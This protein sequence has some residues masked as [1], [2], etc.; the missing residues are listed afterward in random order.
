MPCLTRTTPHLLHLQS[1]PA[2]SF[3]PSSIPINS[4][5]HHNYTPFPISSIAACPTPPSLHP[6]ILAYRPPSI[7]S[8]P[9]PY[10]P[11]VQKFLWGG[12]GRR[13]VL[14]LP[15]IPPLI[16]ELESGMCSEDERQRSMGVRAVGPPKP[17]R[18]PTQHEPN[19]DSDEIQIFAKYLNFV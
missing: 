4:S 6:T 15:H 5:R 11:F 16:L 9:I 18:P 13:P 17:G 14:K 8:H 10:E 1:Y 2:P 12:R 7:P 3:P 19:Q